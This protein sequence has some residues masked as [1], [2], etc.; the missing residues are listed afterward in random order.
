MLEFSNIEMKISEEDVDVD[1]HDQ[2][3]RKAENNR[4]GPTRRNELEDRDRDENKGEAINDAGCLQKKMRR[5]RARKEKRRGSR[6][7]CQSAREV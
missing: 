4:R 6:F 5:K 3:V 7:S 2:S 1:V